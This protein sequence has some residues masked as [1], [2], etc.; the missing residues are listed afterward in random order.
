ME[1]YA[2]NLM[3]E[4]QGRCNRDIKIKSCRGM[5]LLKQRIVAI[6]NIENPYVSR[7]SLWLC[8]EVKSKVTAKQARFR[9]LLSCRTWKTFDGK[10]RDLGSILEETGQEYNFIP[11]EGLKNNSQMVEKASGKLATPFGSASGGV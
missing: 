7:K 6:G 9:E 3:E 8:E 4:P 11:K 10:T 1:G 2:K 5:F